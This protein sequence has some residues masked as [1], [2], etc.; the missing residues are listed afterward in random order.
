MAFPCIG[1]SLIGPGDLEKLTKERKKTTYI[2][3]FRPA[4]PSVCI[5]SKGAFKNIKNE[6]STTSRAHFVEK[7]QRFPVLG[8]I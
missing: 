7:F 6:G 5:F 8:K 1:G 3:I 2:I 4:R